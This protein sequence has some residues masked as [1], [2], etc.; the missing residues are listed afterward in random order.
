M[1]RS[2]TVITIFAIVMLANFIA[3]Q[4]NSASDDSTIHS[5]IY[6]EDSA[7][8]EASKQS[9]NEEVLLETTK[10]AEKGLDRRRY[11]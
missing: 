11:L 8:Y 2:L 5:V 10:A 3:A 1:K 6:S 7:K 4:I 9:V